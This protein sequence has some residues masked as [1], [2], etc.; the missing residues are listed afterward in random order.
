MIRA[1]ILYFLSVKPTHGYEI[2][3]YIQ[4]NQMND[5]TTIQSG[6]IYYALTKLEKE[7]LIEIVRE[8]AIGKKTRKIYGITDKGRQELE[9]TLV[10]LVS[11]PIYN[12]KSDKFVAYPLMSN[13]D[14][15]LLKEKIQTHVD[16]LRKKKY[17]IE[18]WQSIK[19]NE[20]SLGVERI[21]FEMMISSL[22][23]QIRW[24]DMFLSEI[25][26]CRKASGLM[27]EYIEYV[28]FADVSNAEDLYKMAENLI[29]E[30]EL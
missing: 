25:G 6:S 11:M 15:H 1:F 24:H 4:L 17:A 26:R 21:S 29:K 18:E 16:S 27:R 3:K 30:N 19:V 9:S 10:D 23:Y 8:E 7:G 12:E 28:N 20:H 2:Q 13:L 5:W 14:E 22:D